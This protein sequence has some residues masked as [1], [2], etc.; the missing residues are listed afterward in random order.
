M[1]QTVGKKV[2][3]HQ[4]RSQSTLLSFNSIALVCRDEKLMQILV[5]KWKKKK[6]RKLSLI[7]I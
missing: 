7:H 2:T 3:D 5:G 4:L 6:E 1:N